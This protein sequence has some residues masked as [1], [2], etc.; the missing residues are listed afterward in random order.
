VS[1]LPRPHVPHPHV[2]A[3]FDDH[4]WR[5]LPFALAGIVFLTV[6]LIVV[7]FAIS[8]AFTGHAY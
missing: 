4:P 8:K 7:S 6:V 1:H 5:V 3:G 2:D